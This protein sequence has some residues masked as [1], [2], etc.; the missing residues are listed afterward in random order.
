MGILRDAFSGIGS[1]IIEGLRENYSV[2]LDDAAF[3]ERVIGIKNATAA[4]YEAKVEDDIIISLLQ[5]YWDLRLSEA[6][7]ILE[8]EKNKVNRLVE[9]R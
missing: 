6:I 9:D 2:R 3:E 1:E 7:N 4:L 5:K 8:N